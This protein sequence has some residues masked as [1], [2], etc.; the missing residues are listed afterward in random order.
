MTTRAFEY[1]IQSHPVIVERDAS[2]KARIIGYAAKFSELSLDLGGFQERFAVGAFRDALAR[3]D[4]D[5][6]ATFNHN[7][8]MVLGR[9][10]AGSLELAEDSLGLRYV[11]TPP[12][13]QDIRDLL[14]RMESRIIR[15]SSLSFYPDYESDQWQDREGDL[16]I[17]TVVR[18]TEL[19]D[20][21]PVTFAAYPTTTAAA[22]RSAEQILSAR[23]GKPAPATPLDV[24][25]WQVALAG[26]RRVP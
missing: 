13:A 2:G 23:R 21:G 9:Q 6:R 11:I 1:R 20:V 8:D 14:A 3:A 22:V 10:S 18:V 4:V 7:R 5:V 16:P 25:R 24:L 26:K 19:L 12:D 15:E 17:R